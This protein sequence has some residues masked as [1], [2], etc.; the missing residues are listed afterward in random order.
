[1][2]LYLQLQNGDFVAIRNYNTL[3]AFNAATG[4]IHWTKPVT[5]YWTTPLYALA[6]GTMAYREGY[7]NPQL[8]TVD[9]GGNELSRV[10]DPKTVQSWTDHTYHYGSTDSIQNPILDYAMT[11]AA[12]QYANGTAVLRY[13]SPQAGLS[14]I[15]K[16]DLTRNTL[17]ST[18]L[19]NLTAI[20]IS[21]GRLPEGPPFTKSALLSEIQ[22][23]ASSAGDYT[24]DGPSST[25]H[26]DQCLTQGCVA[27]FP[28]WF[29]GESKP[30]NYRVKDEFADHAQGSLSY[31]EGL[32]QYDGSAIWL[33]L[34]DDWDGAW[35]GLNSQYITKLSFTR[36]GQV[37]SYGLGTL[38]HEVLHKRSVGGGFTHKDMWTALGLSSCDGWPHNACSDHIA[39]ACFPDN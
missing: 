37:N 12:Q 19:D 9:A 24:Y 16:T 31:L 28:V 29:T 27:K 1:M 39:T 34:F 14:T 13:Q 26:W 2:K 22:R 30:D 4:Q 33:R 8:V 18:F 25:T 6:D 7:S 35:L 10:A 38:L 5:S 15:S 36:Y 21:N 17:C 20:A 32:S 23:A 11:Y 3:L